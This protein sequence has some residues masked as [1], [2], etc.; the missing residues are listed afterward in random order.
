MELTTNYF[1]AIALGYIGSLGFWFWATRARPA[2]W[3]APR[4]IYFRKPKTELA[5]AL[6]AIL[7]VILLT[8]LDNM[9][10][11]LPRQRGWI[12]QLFFLGVL[13]I[14]WLPVVL[15]LALRRHDLGT[16]LFSLEGLGKKILWGLGASLVGICLFLLVRGR[17]DAFPYL[18]SG[19]WANSR[20]IV[21]IQSIVL[22]VGVGF[23]LTRIIA[24]AGR[25]KGIIFVGALYGLAKYPLYLMQYHMGFLQA[26]AMIIFSG[27]IA[28]IIAYL[29]YDR[30]DVLVIAIVHF[31]MDE[32]QKF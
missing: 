17:F 15:V 28:A 14:V 11:L 18:L 20:L 10:L 6:L 32:V 9:R 21:L 22:M 19:L 2:L 1:L 5:W 12:G 8:V 24:V 31:F 30:Q 27:I 13:L 26:T 29:V 3:P 4:K 7:F 16:C 23:L 25:W